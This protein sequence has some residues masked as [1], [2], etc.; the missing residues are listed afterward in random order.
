MSQHL[1]IAFDISVSDIFG[2]L[3]TGATLVPFSRA[4]DKMFPARTIKIAEVTVWNSTPSV[5]DFMLQAG[6]L[7]QATMP[8]LRLAS[9]VGE[10]LLKRHVEAL[11]NAAP[12]AEIHNAYGPTETTVAVTD[13]IITNSDLEN[14]E[15]SSLCLGTPLDGNALFLVDDNEKVSAREGEIV[16]TGDQLAVEYWEDPKRTTEAF[17]MIDLGKGPERAYFTGDIGRWVGGKLHF[18]ERKDDQVKIR[19]HRVE[20]GAVAQAVSSV[21]GYNAIAVNLNDK[22][23]VVIEGPELNIV[24]VQKILKKTGEILDRY[25]Q[26]SGILTISR[27]PQNANDKIDLK[28]IRRY[29]LK[30]IVRRISTGIHN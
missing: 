28:A 11:S 2:A 12:A 5:I 25:A 24:D 26:P 8:K 16:I 13:T 20:L 4:I 23:F 30:K 22:I 3:T 15:T 6:D 10:P 9:F 27:F 29:A 19:G 14:Q 1:S 17:R 7:S 18:I 21:S